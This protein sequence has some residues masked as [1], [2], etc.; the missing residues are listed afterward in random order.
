GARRRISK[1]TTG[2]HSAGTLLADLTLLGIIVAAAGL[3]GGGP[4]P[5]PWVRGA[6]PLSPRCFVAVCVAAVAFSEPVNALPGAIVA[7]ARGRA[8]AARL[9]ELLP[10][11]EL[12]ASRAPLPKAAPLCLELAL[13]GQ[14]F[15]ALLRPG[16]TL[17]LTGASGSGKSTVLRAITG[18]PASGGEIRPRRVEPAAGK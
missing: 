14:G 1:I 2:G 15:E 9:A 6:G 18:S 13:S 4:L 16:D 12:P 17:L 10:R 8:A 3:L 11:E 5:T 7:L